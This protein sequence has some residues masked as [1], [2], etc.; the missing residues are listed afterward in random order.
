ML[1]IKLK[2][3][4]NY[5]DIQLCRCTFHD[6]GTLIINIGAMPESHVNV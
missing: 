6:G 3:I 4:F 2:F 1:S 5:I